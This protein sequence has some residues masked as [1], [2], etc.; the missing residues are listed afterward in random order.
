MIGRNKR[1]MSG[2]G[3]LQSGHVKVDDCR[4]ASTQR[5]IQL[6]VTEQTGAQIVNLTPQAVVCTLSRS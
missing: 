5:R 3:E 1:T 6:S 4:S 2:T